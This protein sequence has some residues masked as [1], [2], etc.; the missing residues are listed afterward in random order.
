MPADEIV[1]RG[2]TRISDAALEVALN[3]LLDRHEDAWV[4]AMKPNGQFTAM[5]ESVPLRGQRVLEGAISPLELVITSDRPIVIDAWDR[6][7]KQG[8]ANASVHAYGDPTRV[9]GMHFM[10]MTEKYGVVIGVFLGYRATTPPAAAERQVLIPRASV[11]RKDEMGIIL[12]VDDAATAILGWPAD[13]MIG[14]RTLEFIH[15]DDQERAV[16]N[17][18]ELYGREGL[19]QRVRLRHRHKDGSWVWLE[20]TNH[21]H[22]DDPDDACVVADNVDVTEEVMAL[23]ALANNERLLRRLTAALP[24][25]VLYVAADGTVDYG[26]ERLAAI[27]G[28]EWAS[29]AE[30]Q[31]ATAIGQDRA[32]LLNT[33]ST[34]LHEG[35]DTDLSVT[36]RAKADTDLNCDVKMRALVNAAN[37][38]VGAIVCVIDVTEDLKLREELKRRARYDLLTGCLNHASIVSELVDRLA[39]GAPGLTVAVFIDLDEFK[40]INDQYGHAAGDHVLRQI[41]DGLHRVSRDNDLVG[42]LG[43]DE[44]LLVLQTADDPRALTGI[45]N[46]LT[47]A[48]NR[49]ISWEN[50]W[51][52]PGVSIGL[53]YAQAGSGVTAE[54]LV[55]AADAAMYATKRGKGP[56]VVTNAATGSGYPTT[57]PEGA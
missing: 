14:H 16:A 54:R 10:D 9:I 35:R 45:V 57:E 46:R 42:R 18:M 25:G 50:D 53:S 26:N 38:V 23:D 43:G 7:L 55:R 24:V 3:A 51:I 13:E 4:A 19:S 37:E 36:F 31:F 44:F 15:P 33:L 47:G 29:T 49:R 52:S 11:V 56:P 20:V 8:G 6:V 12:S 27:V 21:N 30:E 2:R 39:A 32:L 5:P 40:T 22:L 48:L 17:W 1:G 28:V 41:A 34:V